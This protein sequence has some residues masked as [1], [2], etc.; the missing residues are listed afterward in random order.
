MS[1]RGLSMYYK[2]LYR[3][4]EPLLRRA[5]AIDEQSFGA[6]HPNVA[7]ALN[8]LAQLLQATSRLTE[9]EPLLRRV[10]EILLT[11]TRAT[12][13]AHTHLRDAV[14]NYAGVLT[15][16]GARP[17]EASKRLQLLGPEALAIL[18]R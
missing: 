7:T 11:F 13:H 16:M 1:K 8:N 18:G 12:G 9:A 15:Q 3:E 10:V 17:A 6:D 4:A 14:M 2:G 5:L